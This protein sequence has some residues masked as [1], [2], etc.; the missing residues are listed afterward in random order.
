VAAGQ[1]ERK[2]MEGIVGLFERLQGT[3]LHGVLVAHQP[4]GSGDMHPVIGRRIS[5]VDDAQARIVQVFP[6]PVGIGE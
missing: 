2:D 4:N 6:Q 3:D 1:W 5:T